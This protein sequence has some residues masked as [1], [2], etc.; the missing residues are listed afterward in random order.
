MPAQNTATRPNNGNSGAKTA[1]LIVSMLVGFVAILGGVIHPIYKDFDGVAQR[2]DRI[3]KFM[4]EDLAREV[5]MAEQLAAFKEQTKEIET[6]FVDI[7]RRMLDV[8]N[9]LIWWNKHIPGTDAEQDERLR[10]LE[11]IVFKENVAPRP[12]GR[13]PGSQREE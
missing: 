10:A 7:K 12:P 11:R 13:P 9:W 8:E 3:E 4:R 2:L 6:Q 1:A 5:H